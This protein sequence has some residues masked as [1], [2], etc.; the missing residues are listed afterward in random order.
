MS[1][2]YLGKWPRLIVVGESVTRDQAAQM[3]MQ[4][5]SCY[6]GC[7]D[8]EWEL[9]VA[10]VMGLAP[11]FFSRD[12]NMPVKEVMALDEHD[13]Q[14]WKDLGNLDLHYCVNDRIMSAYV[15]GPHG[16]VAWDGTIGCSSYNVGKWPSEDHLIDDWVRISA[17]FPFLTCGVQFIGNEG[18]GGI[19]LTLDVQEGSCTIVDASEYLLAPESWEET[20]MSALIRDLRDGTHRRERGCT[21]DTLQEALSITR[22]NV[23]RSLHACSDKPE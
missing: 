1:T 19:S 3:I 20:D 21:L 22:Q 17:R 15:G 23:I 12:A 16:W 2:P 7:N 5:S 13:R 11:P 6:Q 4:T 10:A 9:D 14:V 8:H 18:A